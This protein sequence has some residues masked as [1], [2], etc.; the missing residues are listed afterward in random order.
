MPHS[1]KVAIVL[2]GLI[3][4]A[5][6]G[7][8]ATL[9]H[10][11]HMRQVLDTLLAQNI[12][13]MLFATELELALQRQK[14]LVASYLM[15]EGNPRWLEKLRQ[16]EPQFHQ[17]LLRIDQEMDSPRERAILP[18]IRDAFARYDATRDRVVVLYDQGDEMAARSL[19]LNEVSRLYDQTVALCDEIVEINKQDIEEV[20]QQG[21]E[22]I[23][24]LTLFVIF[25]VVLTACLG[26][27][28]L[29]LLFTRVFIPLRRIATDVRGFPV[30]APDKRWFL[31]DDLEGLGYYLRVLMGEVHQARSD[32]ETSRD[33]LRQTEPLAAVGHTVARV[34]HEIKNHLVVI[35]GFARLI[36]KHPDN[37][38]RACSN[39]RTIREEISHL[40]SLLEDIMDFS[41]PFQLDR[42]AQSLNR[43]VEDI[44]NKLG[45]GMLEQVELEVELDPGT[46]EISLDA[47]RFEQVI[48]NLIRNALESMQYQGKLR[49]ATA[50]TPGGA[51]FRIQD[52]GP[53]I[54][55][56]IQERIF[57]PFFTTKKKGNGLGLAICLQIIQEHGGTLYLESSPEQ[58]TTFTIEL[59]AG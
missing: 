7:A 9:L 11:W 43:L 41:R 26:I 6:V 33:R 56:D 37:P 57:E 22:Q 58:G 38:Q 42:R 53:G 46:P 5:M 39:A 8:A 21:R 10:A 51:T 19:Y 24:R 31:Q 2:A 15:D 35:G 27:G 49:L 47:K 23:G 18:R 13:E 48:L 25:S 17:D 59:P 3:G 14:G 16:I 12:S 1:T 40:E 20:L 28:L 55:R 44:V 50:P 45:Q 29:W 34:A 52:N 4:L 36:E 30:S 32:L 54:P